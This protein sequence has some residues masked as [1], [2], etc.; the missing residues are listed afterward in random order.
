MEKITIHHQNQPWVLADP[1]KPS[2]FLER[3]LWLHR[4][5][6]STKSLYSRFNT[7]IFPIYWCKKSPTESK[8]ILFSSSASFGSS[9]SVCQQP[10]FKWKNFSIAEWGIFVPKI[11][12]SAKKA[13]WR[14]H[15]CTHG[16]SKAA[17]SKKRLNS[18]PHFC[19]LKTWTGCS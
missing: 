12:S 17:T 9:C 2:V 15:A 6:N 7:T 4:N 18:S 1:Q 10:K 16:P 3:L 11:Y 19:H 8:G 5:T 14:F 13:R